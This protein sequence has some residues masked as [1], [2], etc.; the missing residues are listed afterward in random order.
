M[1]CVAQRAD[2]DAERNRAPRMRM[3]EF[4]YSWFLS[5]LNA[6]IDVSSIK[7]G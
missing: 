5:A 1:G 3:P 4:V 7:G 6:P 2:A